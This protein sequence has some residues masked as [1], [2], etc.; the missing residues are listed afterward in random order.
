MRDR[1]PSKP[2][3]HACTVYVQ[4]E[5]VADLN[6]EYK[7]LGWSR[8]DIMLHHLAIAY[9]R[10]EFDPLPHYEAAK[11]ALAAAEQQQMTA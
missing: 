8:S 2:G 3:F 7:A 5:F 9:G 10:P 6:A 1:P 4:N 11:A